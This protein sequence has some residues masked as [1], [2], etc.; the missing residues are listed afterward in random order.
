[1][2][3]RKVIAKM[4]S[5]FGTG[6]KLSEKYFFFQLLCTQV[7][8]FP[9]QFLG[10]LLISFDLKLMLLSDTDKLDVSYFS[11]PS[12]MAHKFIASIFV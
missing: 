5:T 7:E 1:M 9:S 6:A 10:F 8:I 12:H 3:L 4:L 11:A 2:N